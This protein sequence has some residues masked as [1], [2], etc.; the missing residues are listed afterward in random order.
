MKDKHTD[1]IYDSAVVCDN[2]S[3]I[4]VLCAAHSGSGAGAHHGRVSGAASVSSLQQNTM[5]VDRGTRNR[6]TKIIA[7]A[8]LSPN[9]YGT[10]K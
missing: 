1:A 8:R 2:D 5:H 10:R 4:R 9:S 7:A 6:K 3:A